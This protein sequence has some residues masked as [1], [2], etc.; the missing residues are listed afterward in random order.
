MNISLAEHADD[1]HKVYAGNYP[2]LVT[3][4]GRS[5]TH[6]T[7]KFLSLHGIDIG[8][9]ET[10][11]LGSVSWLCAS[12]AYCRDRN[13]HFEKKLHQI[14]H[15]LSFIRSWQT[16]NPRAWS[17]I[18][19]YAPQCLHPDNIVAAARYWLH[20]NEM[21]MSGAQLSLRLEDFSEI[22]META[23]RLSRFFD[24]PLNPALIDTAR[25]SGDS[26]TRHRSYGRD[27]NLDLIREKDPQTYNG[28]SV[29]ADQFGYKL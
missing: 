1:I 29:L 23:V 15:P 11:P 18:A 3:G 22:P 7:A 10:A 25:E 13:A 21:A 24:R 6:F 26:R 9:E 14:R 17:Y 28:M 19:V 5:G 12:D 8:H 20:W 2:Y 4:C 27:S 16:V